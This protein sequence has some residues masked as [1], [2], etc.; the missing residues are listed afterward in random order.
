MSDLRLWHGGAP[1]LR[2]GELIEP[3]PEGDTR[4]LLDGCPTCEAMKFGDRPKGMARVDR[5]YVTTDREYARLYASGYPRGALYRVEAVG[6]ME[7]TTEDDDPY[8]SWA[9]TSARVLSV[10]DAVVRLS[11]REARRLMRRAGIRL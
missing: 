8:P 2:A 6:E 11:E 1:G 4:H 7:E 3:R 9:T 10:Y 5:V